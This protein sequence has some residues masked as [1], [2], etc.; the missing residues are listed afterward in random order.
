MKTEIKSVIDSAS[1]KDIEIM[2]K[3][4]LSLFR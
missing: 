3:F 2:H 1:E 4:C